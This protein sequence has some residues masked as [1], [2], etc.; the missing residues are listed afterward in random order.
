MQSKSRFLLGF[1]L[2]LICMSIF[3]RYFFGEQIQQGDESIS[4]TRE[5]WWTWW[6]WEKY[7]FIDGLLTEE[8]VDQEKIDKEKMREHAI[9]GYV[10]ALGDPYTVYLTS[11]ENE[12][13]EEEMKWGQHFEGIGAVVTKKE[14][15]IL[16][17]EVL[18]GLPAYKA[19]LRPLDV[20][21]AIDGEETKSL[22][23]NEAVQKIRGVKGTEVVLTIYREWVEEIL[24]ITVVR[25][26]VDVPSVAWEILQVDDQSVLYIEISIIGADTKK[27]FEKT[28]DEYAGQFEGI[29]LDLRGNGGGYLPSAVDIVSFFLPDNELIT[30]AR[31]SVW[32]DEVYRSEGY[33]DLENIPVVV[34]IDGLSASASEIIA[35]ALD[36]RDDAVL[37]GTQTFGKW[38]IQTLADIEDGSSLKYTIGKRYAPSDKNIDKIGLTPDIEVEFDL[39]AYLENAVDNQLERAKEEMRKLIGN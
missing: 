7:N 3:W 21:L 12:S 23:L 2:G 25:D 4:L 11:E 32:A 13:F 20:I 35:S 19:W 37:V 36:E 8:Y 38:S 10:D 30:T 24:E 9:K 1:L 34:L 31:Y 39:D 28:I 22:W 18:K 27:V 6:S 33:G 17:E 15:G 29:I 26:T 14:D 16:I 5:E